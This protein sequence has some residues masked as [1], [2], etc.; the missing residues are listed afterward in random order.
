MGTKT[1]VAERIISLLPSA[2]EVLWFLGHGDRVVGVTFECNEPPTAAELPHVTDTIVPPG[3]TPAEIDA[4][5]KQAMAEGNELYRLDRELLASLD[6]DLIVS[7]DLCRVC[8]LPSGD[9]D[10]AVRELGCDAA[11][12]SYDPMTLDGVLQ[13]MVALDRL[14]TGSVG[15]VGPEPRAITALRDRLAAVRSRVAGMPRPK[16]LL[17][18]WPDPPFTPGHWIPDLI[19]QAGGEPVLAHPGERSEA[20]TWDAVADSDAEVLLV[21]PCGF[22]QEAAE[23]QLQEVLRRPEVAAMPAVAAG[24]T[25]AIDADGLIVRPGPRLVDGVEVL[26]RLLHP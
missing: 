26:S 5:I 13:E 6:P 8:A 14:V 17:L 3:L 20:T 2:T 1:S 18:E 23:A 9:V 19:D 24:R 15:A 22:D 12:F 21:A 11:V 25:Y 10:A 7:Q 16:V 4:V